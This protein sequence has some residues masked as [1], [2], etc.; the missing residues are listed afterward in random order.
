MKKLLLLGNNCHVDELIKHAKERG[1]YT[2]VTDNL[3]LEQSPVK[4]MADEAWNLSVLDI[5]TI[6]ERCKQEKI[7][8]ILC[9]ASE[10]CIKANKE[11]CER[12]NLP[13]YANQKAWDITNDKLAFKEICQECGIPVPY[14]YDLDIELRADDLAKIKY[15]AVVKPADGCSGIG[16]HICNNEAELTEGYLDAYEKSTVKKVIVEEF[17]PG[18][19]VGLIYGVVDGVPYLNAAGDDCACKYDAHR[20]VFGACPTKHKKMFEAILEKPIIQLF[21]K[22]EIMAGVAGIQVITDGE[23]V[24]VIEMNYRL[25]GGKFPGEKFLCD[26]MLDSALGENTNPVVVPQ[27]GQLFSYA[28]WLKPGKIAEIKGLDILEARPQEFNI[29]QFRRPGDIVQENTGMKQVLGYIM[30]F[31][32]VEHHEEY[33]ELINNTVKVISETGKDLVYHY[34]FEKG[35]AV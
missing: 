34:R 19:Q 7:D 18:E 33:I 6:E 27:Q 30:F 22:L 13:F 28:I 12:L 35:Y 2:I 17:V 15:P 23:K 16:L 5:D 25:P 3:S 9:G 14:E 32:D 24:A 10:V 31:T 20:R 11:L 4:A 1:V 21:E 26:V 29:Q 8:A